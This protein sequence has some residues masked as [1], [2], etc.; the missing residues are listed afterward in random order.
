M[1]L[2][3]LLQLR[4]GR[5]SIPLRPLMLSSH[6]L[7]HASLARY[8]AYCEDGEGRHRRVFRTILKDV[9]LQPNKKRDD[10]SGR[11]SPERWEVGRASVELLL[12]AGA[13]VGEEQRQ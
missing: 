11:R 10:A 7:N 1:E 3:L 8:V 6:T 4:M 2:P 5:R 9:N 12:G 13:D